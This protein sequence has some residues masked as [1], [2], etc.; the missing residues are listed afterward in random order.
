M[1]KEEQKKWLEKLRSLSEKKNQELDRL[2]SSNLPALA[3]KTFFN[4]EEIAA[5][6]KVHAKKMEPL[7]REIKILEES[8]IK[9][10]IYRYPK[11]EEGDLS[12]GISSFFGSKHIFIYPE[13]A[14]DSEGYSTTEVVGTGNHEHYTENYRAFE[15]MEA[16]MDFV[17]EYIAELSGLKD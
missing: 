12:I 6:K 4:S 5:F 15:D 14:E 8:Y 2:K 13:V 7:V 16:V 3:P 10:F 11:P 1:S 9:D 17:V